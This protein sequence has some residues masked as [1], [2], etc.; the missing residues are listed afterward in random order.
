LLK[1]VGDTGELSRDTLIVLG[2]LSGGN[3]PQRCG[4]RSEF[5]SKGSSFHG[6]DPPSVMREAP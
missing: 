5:S 1:V 6:G 2:I 3:R 4:P